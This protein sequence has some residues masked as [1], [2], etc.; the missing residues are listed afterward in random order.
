MNLL[1]CLESVNITS[2][3]H[4]QEETMDQSGRFGQVKAR[5]STPKVTLSAPMDHHRIPHVIGRNYRIHSL[6]ARDAWTDFTHPQAGKFTK[7]IG[8]HSRSQDCSQMSDQEEIGV[9]SNQ[10]MRA[11]AGMRWYALLYRKKHYRTLG[12]GRQLILP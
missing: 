2:W 9:P 8:V 11:A 4:S 1:N 3:E 7:P 12:H 6:E 5:P 10:T